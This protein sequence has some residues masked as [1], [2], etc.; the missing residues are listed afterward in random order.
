[1][2]IT[3]AQLKR[4]IKEEKWRFHEACGDPLANDAIDVP[5]S[6][7]DVTSEPLLVS[8][9]DTPLTDMLVEME[10]ASRSL[11]QVVESVQNAAHLCL[12]C[13]PD[14][15]A[16]APMVEAMVSQA[17]ALQ[18]M[19]DAQSEVLHENVGSGNGDE[20]SSTGD[21][22]LRLGGE[23]FTVGYEAGKQGLE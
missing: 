2:K 6:V 12:D 15:A 21:V 23:A 1:M 3:E 5:V 10:V 17:E 11:Q 18:E 9:S 8:E 7:D 16:Q 13:G 19:L 22:G 20:F 4:I 14:A